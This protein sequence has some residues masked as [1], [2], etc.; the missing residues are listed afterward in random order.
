MLFSGRVARRRPRPEIHIQRMKARIDTPEGRAATADAG[1]LSADPEAASTVCDAMERLIE[2]RESCRPGTAC[3]GSELAYFHLDALLD[4][5]GG[6]LQDPAGD[7]LAD[8]ILPA[9]RA[10]EC[11]HPFITS[12]APPRSTVTIVVPS[13]GS[14]WPQV[15]QIMGVVSGSR[16][17]KAA[18]PADRP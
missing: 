1:S 16:V 7:L 14:A 18:E 4:H 2:G 10:H 13:P 5:L 8:V 15:V 17:P 11:G 9:V 3:S 12:V 6:R